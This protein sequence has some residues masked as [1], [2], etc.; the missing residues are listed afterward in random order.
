MQEKTIRH[1]KITLRYVHSAR[2][3]IKYLLYAN[4]KQLRRIG[5]LE[6]GKLKIGRRISVKTVKDEGILNPARYSSPVAFSKQDCVSAID[7]IL[8]KIDENLEAY[9]ELKFPDA[10]SK[11]NVYAF[12]EVNRG[13]TTSFWTGMLWLAYE[14]TGNEKYR[15]AAEK[16]LKSYKKRIDEDFDTDTHDLGFIYTLSCVA[17]YKLTGNAEARA[18]ALKAADKLMTRFFEKAGIIQAWGDLNDPEQQGRMII[19]CCMNLPLLYWASAETGDEKYAQAAK[20]HAEKA[21]EYIVR[22]DASTYHTFY[23]DVTTGQ[24]KFGKTHQGY[25]DTSCW[26]RGQAWGMYG[27]PLSYLYTKNF[28]LIE[29][30]KKLS[31]YFLNRLPSD[32]ICYWDLCFTD[33]AEERDSSAA[34]IGVCGL[35]EMTKLLPLTDPYRAVYENASLAIVKSLAE[36]YTSASDPSSNGVLL[37]AVYGKPFNSGVDECNIW[38]DYFYFEA[39][40]R[41][42]K[43]WRLYW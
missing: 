2:H 32:D 6:N 28:D 4:F 13:W 8:K 22:E 19:D 7:F 20:S 12:S 11:N 24:P 30:S 3:A 36:R 23:M 43:D 1:D 15:Q 26:S 18:S 29:V 14:V 42:I 10:A 37:H 39:L 40:V 38:G 41:L 5:L 16:Q 9:G 31:N 35:L 25:S 21:A 34:A 33:G 27:F 17:G